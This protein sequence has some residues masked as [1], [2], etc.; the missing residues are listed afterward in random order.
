MRSTRRCPKRGRT[1][2]AEVVGATA[3]LSAAV[4][5]LVVSAFLFSAFLRL[6]ASRPPFAYT[7]KSRDSEVKYS[8]P[9]L[10]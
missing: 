4:I 1:A 3:D 10:L 5:F 8:N 7:V 6:S 9:E 2:P